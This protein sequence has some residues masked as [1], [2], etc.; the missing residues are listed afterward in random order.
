MTTKEEHFVGQLVGEADQ[1]YLIAIKGKKEYVS[2]NAG[3]N[4]HPGPTLG[5]Y[6]TERASQ[7]KTFVTRE[8]AQ[9]ECNRLAKIQHYTTVGNRVRSTIE[10]DILVASV[11]VEHK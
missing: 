11:L 9:K 5:M 7:A 6:S 3:N 8:S 1:F 10:F 2:K 4:V